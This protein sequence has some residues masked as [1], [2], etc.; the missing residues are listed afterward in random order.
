MS[1]TS[2]ENSNLSD[3]ARRNLWMHFS[4][5]GTY[6]THEVPVIVRGE[7][8]YVWDQHGK[9]YLDGLAGLFT[10]Q[11]GHGRTEL[12]EAGAKQAGTLAYFPLWT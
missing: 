3:Q 6:E 7:G 9:R 10:S 5:M 2:P 8:A 4:R 1:T 12:A 11:I